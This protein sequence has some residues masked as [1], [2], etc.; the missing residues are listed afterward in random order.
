MQHFATQRPFTLLIAAL[1]GEGGGVLSNWVV[2]AAAAHGYPVQS[3]SIPGV[4]QRTGATTYYVEIFPLHRDALSGSEPVLALAPTPGCIDLMVASELL[5]AGR[6]MQHGYVS[7]ER[8]TLITSSHRIYAIAEKIAMGDGRFDGERV[9]EGANLLARRAIV[10]DMEAAARRTGTVIS[11]VMFGAMSGAGV[12]PLSR[13]ACE[14]AIRRSGKGAEASLKGFAAGFAFAANPST[15]EIQRDAQRA[16]LS[17][18]ER[19]QARF[20]AATHKIVDAGAARTAAYQDERYAQLYL[21]RVEQMLQLEEGSG[22]DARFALTNETARFL[23]LWMCYED[24]MRVADLK[25]RAA[26]L[27]RVRREAGA[28]GNEPV[29]LTE[30]LKPGLEEWCS[31]LPRRLARVLRGWAQRRGNASRFNIGLHVRTTTLT[32]FLMLRLLAWFKRYRRSTLRYA[33]EQQLIERWLAA[34]RAAGRRAPQLALEIALLGRLIKGYGDTHAR[35]QGNFLRIMQTLVEANV[36]LDDAARA[37][38]VRAAREAALADPEGRTLEDHLG[39]HGIAPLPPR[40]Q[41][42][43][44]VRRRPAT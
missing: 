13:A 10:F 12:L 15:P 36:A 22:D 7:P 23:A 44:F 35:G 6:A 34:I 5:E 25:T 21:D 1:G 28:Q 43:H 2:D 17:P 38:A 14:E 24:V 26:R 42:I 9:L 37:Q 31:V 27:E 8:T 40:P 30:Y 29:L 39:S 11:A 16:A 4:A 33:Q 18:R 3:T 41:P 32:G 20:P 19:V